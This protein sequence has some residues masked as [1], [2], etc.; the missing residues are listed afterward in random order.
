MLVRGRIRFS[1]RRVGHISPV[2]PFGVSIVVPAVAGSFDL[3]TVVVRAAIQID[4]RTAQ[5]K[6]VSDLLPTILDGI[7]LDLRE[8]RVAIDRPGFMLNPTSCA[9]KHVDATITSVAGAVANVSSRFQ[10]AECASLGFAP[11]MVARTVARHSKRNGVAFFT[12]V[13]SG[14]GQANIA[15]VKVSLPKILPSRLSTLNKA[16]LAATFEADPASCPAASVVGHAKA[17]TRLLRVPLEGPAYFVSHGGAGFPDMEIVL[18][19]E[20][21]TIDLVGRTSIKNG[22]TSVVFGE[23][24]DAPVASFELTLPAGANSALAATGDLCRG[25][26]VMPTSFTGQNGAQINGNTRIAVQGCPKHKHKAKKRH[27]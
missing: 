19:G 18:Q 25:K 8:V 13:T 7:P 27:K 2:A 17:V 5:L 16:C 10:A 6:V 24:P 23:V 20:G 26:L 1:S 11:R 21:I 4:R 3:G 12:K 14:A 15:R 9:V 22:V